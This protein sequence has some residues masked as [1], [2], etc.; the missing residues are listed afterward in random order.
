MSIKI[1]L[2]ISKIKIDWTS[3][4]LDIKLR[5]ILLQTLVGC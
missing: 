3:T 5:T 1:V 2:D 4:K